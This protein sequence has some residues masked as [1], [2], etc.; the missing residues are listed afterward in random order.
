MG[1]KPPVVPVA[2]WT[3]GVLCLMRR[4]L[5]CV[6][7]LVCCLPLAQT[8]PSAATTQEPIVASGAP[9]LRAEAQKATAAAGPYDCFLSSKPT[10][11]LANS[12][13]FN[14]ATGAN[15]AKYR[16]V[17]KIIGAIKR[18]PRGESIRIMS[19]N[20]MSKAATDALLAAQRRGVLIYVLMD[21]TNIS[22]DVP[23]PQFARLKKGLVRYN[24]VLPSAKRS[25]AKVCLGACRRGKAGSSHSKYYLFSRI[26]LS[27]NVVIQGSAN[28]TTAAAANQWNDI[29]TYVDKPELYRFAYAIFQQMWLDRA[30]YPSY[31]GYMSPAKTYGLYFSPR[32]SASHAGPEPKDDL[33]VQQLRKVTCTGATNTSSGRTVIRAVPDVIRGKWGDQVAGALKYLWN[34]GCDIKMGY[35]VLGQST[36]KILK[37]SSGRGAVPIRHLASDVDGDGEFDKY[38]HMK[39]WTIVGNMEGNTG[40][41][42]TMNGSSNI[43]EPSQ[44]SDENIGIFKNFPSVTLAYQ[45]HIDYWYANPPRSRPIIP[46]KVPANLDPYANVDLD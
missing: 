9:V 36:G 18:T 21:S 12:L 14:S 46:S 43:S 40:S 45:K 31:K 2:I 22:K 42:W 33:L 37:S 10:C 39:V 16:I 6:V 3:K 38:F 25:Y 27:E 35:T 15:S 23:N 26:G 32:V 8:L 34:K 4:L 1:T 28:L 5:L 19:W 11:R 13:T 17:N 30:F 20:I 41:Y 7:A 29:Y 24:K 44:I